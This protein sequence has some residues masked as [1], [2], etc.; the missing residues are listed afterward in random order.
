MI[1]DDSTVARAVLKRMISSARELEVV[2][3]AQNALE[4]LDILD[5]LTLD[6]VLLDVEMPGMS[7]LEALPEISRRA[8]GA[9]IL[10]LSS[11]CD[12]GAEAKV[13]ALTLG[14]ADT[15]PKPGAGYFAGRFSE[16]LIERLRRIG[17]ADPAAS[18]SRDPASEL[19][20]RPFPNGKLG[21]LA[22]GA[23]TGGPHALSEFLRTLPKRIGAPI[24]IT[25]HLPTPFISVFARQMEAASGRLASVA[26]EG[27]PIEPERIYVAPGDAHLGL[28]RSGGRILVSLKRQQAQSGC[29]PSVDTMLTLV[30]E[31][32]GRNCTAVI[33]SGMGK[34]GLAGSHDIAARGGAILVQDQSSAVWGMPRAVADAGLASAILPPAELSRRVASQA[35]DISGK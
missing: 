11:V 34:D 9:R 26:E 18:M 33:F 29:L 8:R 2:A 20:L 22:L 35:R 14:A 1:V 32:Y 28:R 3:E 10:I 13:R 31:I 25:Q 21:C 24:L 19:T 12:E 30:S 5:S 16:V 27:Q 15:L 6:I 23:S 7:G 4:A 17:H